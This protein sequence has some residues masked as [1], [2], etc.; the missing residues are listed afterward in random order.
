MHVGVGIINLD[1]TKKSAR[2]QRASPFCSWPTSLGIR[3]WYV[4]EIAIASTLC[5]KSQHGERKM[6]ETHGRYGGVQLIACVWWFNKLSII[7]K[8]G[9]RW[10]CTYRLL[11]VFFQHTHSVPV[12]SNIRC[13][14]FSY[15]YIDAVVFKELNIF[16]CLQIRGGYG[17]NIGTGSIYFWCVYIVWL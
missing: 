15:T 16:F 5:I 11:L 14:F 6:G 4:D 17:L 2:A 12:I 7:I 10:M 13:T 3:F 1:W 8:K 9:I